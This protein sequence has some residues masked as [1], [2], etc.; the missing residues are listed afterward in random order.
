MELK[1]ISL[2]QL[3]NSTS[4]TEYFVTFAKLIGHSADSVFFEGITDDDFYLLEELENQ[5]GYEVPSNY[6][7]FLGHLN[8]GHFLNIDF[9]SLA[10]KEYLNSLYN[11]NFINTIRSQLDIEDN[12]LIIGKSENYIMY[13][14]CLDPDGVYTL[15]D[16]RNKEK[17][18]FESFNSLIGFIFYMIVI[19]N[20]K[21]MQEE[22]ERIEEMKETLHNEIVTKNKEWKKEKEKKSAKLRAKSAARGLREKE[23]KARMKR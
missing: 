15:M 3:L 10:K 16:I 11:R 6:M 18:E 22:K 7:D 8:G 12:V 21:K 17:I 9:F 4:G 20:N 14:D 13:V 19:N 2:A 1:E 23:R 5:L